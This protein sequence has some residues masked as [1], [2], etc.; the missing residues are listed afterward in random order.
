MILEGEADMETTRSSITKTTG[1][2]TAVVVLG[3]PVGSGKTRENW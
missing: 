1:I 3:V 2:Y